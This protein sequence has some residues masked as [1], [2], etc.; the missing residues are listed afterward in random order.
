VKVPGRMFPVEVRYLDR[1]PADPVEAAVRAVP[2][3]FAETE[4]DLLVF[5]PDYR[6]IR[7]LLEELPTRLPPDAEILCLYGDQ[8]PP[9]QR[10]A[11][12]GRD[13]ARR[14]VIIAT[15]VAE[16]SVTLDGVTAVVDT[17]LIKVKD[18][19]PGQA[20][21][22]LKAR[23]HARAG[24]DQRAGRAGRTAPGV[25][26]RLMAEENFWRRREFA[27]P[28]ILRTGLDEVLLHLLSLG[29]SL[30]DV[31]AFGW[32][33]PPSAEMWQDAREQL[34]LLGALTRHGALTET[35]RLMADL[36]LPPAVSK[37]ILAAREG[38]CVD[39]VVTVA[40][41]FGTK[42]VFL[43]P[44]GEEDTADEAHARFLNPHSDFLTVLKTVAAW[45]R[46]P[47]GTREAFCA[48]HYLNHRALTEIE[49]VRRQL[50]ELLKEHDIEVS[51]GTDPAAIGKAVTAG[52]LRNLLEQSRDDS[53]VYHAAHC[54]GVYFSPD[55]ALAARENFPPFAV[56]A[57]VCETTRP[58]AR[59]VQAVPSQWLKEFGLMGRKAKGPRREPN[60][61]NAR[62]RR[63]PRQRVAAKR[64]R[65]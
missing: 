52:L 4:G 48:E 31:T 37:M 30:E 40:A 63:Q 64:R 33:T 56:C 38:Q 11:V 29:F 50:H 9:E 19:R 41:S 54:R 55:S 17:G 49:A 18:Y 20:F 60:P 28:E 65:R 47:A 5:V 36:P 23:W 16:T 27:R 45:R 46:E 53:R 43:R 32:L 44:P 13:P 34:G 59:R 3:L 8:D 7:F 25:C 62:Q 61:K 24:L 2:Q 58:F 22:T 42:P 14:H 6:A 51:D 1:E 39:A 35:G 57:E 15:N 10:R 12:F 26:L 21:S